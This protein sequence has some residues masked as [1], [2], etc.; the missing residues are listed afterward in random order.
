VPD[1]MIPDNEVIPGAIPSPPPPENNPGA[2]AP[3]DKCYRDQHILLVNI[4][5]EPNVGVTTRRR[6]VIDSKDAS[7]SECLYVNFLSNIKPK[8]VIDALKEEGW[9]FAIQEE[10]N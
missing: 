3:Q 6:R 5:G 8:K 7:A 2:P 10:L 1:Q 4:L 9:V